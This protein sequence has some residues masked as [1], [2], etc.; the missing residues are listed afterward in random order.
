MN[1]DPAA[2]R[3]T[4]DQMRQGLAAFYEQIAATIDH[5]GSTD[6]Q[7]AFELATQH[8][9]A[10]RDLH[11]QEEGRASRLRARQAVRIREKEALSLAALA[12]RIGVSKS[13]ADQLVNL[14]KTTVGEASPTEEPVEAS[15]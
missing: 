9:L 1:H 5:L 14:A 8:A 11:D 3:Q 12:D 7:A 13:R 4:L 6:P 10:L 2:V 15:P